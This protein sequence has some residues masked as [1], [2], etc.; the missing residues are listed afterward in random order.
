MK[1]RIRS[2]HIQRPCTEDWASM[3]RAEGQERYCSRCAHCVT[4]F[5]VLRDR[6]IVDQLQAR[7]GRIC[8]RFT[9]DQLDRVNLSL[10]P[11]PQPSTWRSAL[12][13][14]AG[15][16]CTVPPAVATAPQAPVAEALAQSQQPSAMHERQAGTPL[17]VKGRVL[18]ESDGTPLDGATINF[19]G[20]NLSATTDAEGRFQVDLGVL[21]D[22]PPQIDL[23]ITRE[24]FLP[25][26]FTLSVT[27]RPLEL[28]ISLQEEDFLLGVIVMETPERSYPSTFKRVSRWLPFKNRW[29]Q[30][31]RGDA[32]GPFVRSPDG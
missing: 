3:D 15:I 16:A 27:D 13:A 10:R 8:G 23:A 28:T 29:R 6:E 5:T 4:D 19:G 20:T 18:K 14:L 1:P 26:D 2:I 32:S 12:L 30:P 25:L 11:E 17:I 22:L 24:G 7:E 21:T 31:E 9:R